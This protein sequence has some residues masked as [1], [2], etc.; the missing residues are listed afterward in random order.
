MQLPII[1]VILSLVG[2]VF[3]WRK[4]RDLW[5][6][7]SV[8]LFLW[9]LV[10]YL[11]SLR[12]YNLID[13]STKAYVFV[14]IGV[15]SFFIGSL[16]GDNLRLSKKRVNQWYEIN[17]NRMNIASIIIIVFSLFRILFILKLL[18]GGYSWWEIRL[19][20]TSEEGGLGTLKGGN[21]SMF[22]HDCII[23]PL[24]YLIVPTLFAELLVGARNKKFMILAVAAMTCYSISTVSRA[25]WAFSILYILFIVLLYRREYRFSKKVKRMM[26]YGIFVVFLL[27]IIIYRITLMRNVEA[28][29]L[30][31]MYSYITGC[32]PLLTLH[33][34]EMTSSIRTYGAMSL[35]GFLYPIFF[36]CNYL[37]IF[38]YP[39]AF[40]DAQFVKNSLEVFMPLSPHITMNAYVTLF[41]YFYIDFGYFGI[42]LGSFTFGYL[43]MKSYKCFKRDGDIRSLVL[44]LILMQ[45]I[46]FSVARIYTGL[47]TRALSLVWIMFMFYEVRVKMSK[48]SGEVIV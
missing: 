46:V 29:V 24:M 30:T 18:S 45:F 32:M 23:A 48:K 15:V 27:C 17:Y 19:M 42:F 14:L 26:K 10:V 40:V 20:S 13:I 31:N 36:V 3:F 33:L 38:P 5:N 28:D 9:A 16:F 34:E 21:V 25:V 4:R 11:A 43:C 1:I 37:H 41:Y 6:P 2:G 12:L 44:Y 8:F 39:E 7:A 22:V 35:N 47:S